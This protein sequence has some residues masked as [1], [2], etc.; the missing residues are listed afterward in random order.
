MADFCA[1][2]PAPLNVP[3]TQ[4]AVDPVLAVAVLSSV[5]HPAASATTAAAA[6]KHFR[7]TSRLASGFE[8]I[9]PPSPIPGDVLRGGKI[10]KNVV[11][12]DRRA[13]SGLSQIRTVIC[14]SRTVI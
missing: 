7:R 10:A 6:T 11:K 1:L 2:L 12:G 5:P 8:D 13:W 3:D 14:V 9:F 4:S